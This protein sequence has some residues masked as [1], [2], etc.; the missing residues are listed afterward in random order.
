MRSRAQ[1]HNQAPRQPVPNTGPADETAT[2]RPVDD[3]FSYPDVA[4]LV[5][6]YIV[7]IPMIERDR[8]RQPAPPPD[9]SVGDDFQVGYVQWRILSAENLGYELSAN[10]DRR[11]TD[12]RFV[13]VRFQF[14]NVGSGPL[15]YDGG[16]L[17]KRKGVPL[18]DR[19]GPRICAYYLECTN[20][21]IP[22]GPHYPKDFVPECRRIV[23]AS[24]GRGEDGGPTSLKPNIS[25]TI[26]ITSSMRS[27]LMRLN[28]VLLWQ[29]NWDQGQV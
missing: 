27:M 22:D 18:R 19:S 16:P 21:A 9:Q 8:G 2:V 11:T 14:L 20:G 24:G 29:A 10:N 12:E 25:T 13:Q 15:E 26:C 7:P 4:D 5:K 6:V 23:T 28:L 3:E 1:A 17:R